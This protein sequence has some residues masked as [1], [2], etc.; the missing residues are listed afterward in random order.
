MDHEQ[1]TASSAEIERLILPP[2]SSMDGFF[3]S[4]SWPPPSTTIHTMLSSSSTS[5]NSYMDIASPI[6]RNNN[7]PWSPIPNKQNEPH[8][9]RLDYFT[10]TAAAPTSTN[11]SCSSLSLSPMDR[12]DARYQGPYNNIYDNHFRQKSLPQISTFRKNSINSIV[13]Q[14]T[15]TSAINQ[16]PGF[17][18]QS[19]N[20]P[21]STS[22][23]NSGQSDMSTSSNH[24]QPLEFVL[25]PSSLSSPTLRSIE[26]DIDQV[27][28]VLV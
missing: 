14:P 28:C 17:R 1:S 22:L 6:S 5:N 9:H 26:K 24:A 11:S 19:N 15:S 7:E 2:I 23:P 16:Q 8:S 21:L 18:Y 13:S 4:R 10:N 20:S 25:T 3:A 27:S 12:D